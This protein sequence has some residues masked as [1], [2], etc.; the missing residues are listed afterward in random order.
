LGCLF[1]NVDVV[2]AFRRQPAAAS[3]RVLHLQ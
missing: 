2:A 3:R 1:V